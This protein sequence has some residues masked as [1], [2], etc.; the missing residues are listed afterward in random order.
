MTTKEFAIALAGVAVVA[1]LS[2]NG[3]VAA[4]SQPSHIHSG[5]HRIQEVIRFA[6]ARSE[7]FQDLVA[8]LDLS[9]R[10]VYV[11]EGTCSDSEHRSCVRL[12]P[13][14]RNLLIHFDP[15]QSIRIAA[16]VLA[17]ELYHA[18]EISRAPEVVDNDTLCALYQQIGDLSCDPQ[19][20]FPCWETRAAQTFQA[21]VMRQLTNGALKTDRTANPR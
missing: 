4:E 10:V 17:H 3:L 12:M 16:A 18:A 5:N 7:S 11:E 19:S 1:T 14:T 9:D 8:T 6:L 21:L 15:R 13:N 20:R 2:T